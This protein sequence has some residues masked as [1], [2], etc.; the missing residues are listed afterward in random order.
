M[1]VIAIAVALAALTVAGCSSKPRI[2]APEA[3]VKAVRY[4]S[5]PPAEVRLYTVINKKTGSGEHSGLLISGSQRVLFD[6][7]G[8]WE[9]PKAPERHDVKYGI[10]DRILAFY[11]D[12]HV[13][14]IYDVIVQTVPV[15][16]S[17]AD[18]M[19]ARAEKAGPVGDALCSTSITALLR[20][21]PGFESLRGSMFPKGLSKGFAEIPGVEKVLI[22]NDNV[23]Q[24][25]GVKLIVEVKPKAKDL[26]N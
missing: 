24:S 18:D 3:E 22:T 15:S 17:V 26:T 6:P 21:T 2:F 19:I 10:D 4:I 9:H 1:R 11:V 5:R 8:T 7:A 20:D 14:E 12:Y 23:D 13:R 25:H 16:Q